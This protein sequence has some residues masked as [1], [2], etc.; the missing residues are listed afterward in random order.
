[1]TRTERLALL[2]AL[3]VVLLA[4]LAA[5]PVAAVLGAAA[6]IAV[7]VAVQERLARLSDRMDARL[8]ADVVVARPFSLGPPLLR[9]GL[10]LGVLAGLLVLTVFIPFVGDELFA[11]S[12]AATT[13]LPAT[14]TA[15]RLRR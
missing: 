3:A 2:A 8:G 1:M 14:I 15:L 4:L 10:L 13:A 11:A 9:F 6:G 5:E 12:A 7:G